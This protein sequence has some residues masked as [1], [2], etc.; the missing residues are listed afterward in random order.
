MVSSPCVDPRRSAVPPLT[1]RPA[2]LAAAGAANR[3]AAPMAGR[4]RRTPEPLPRQ[5]VA[6]GF[7]LSGYLGRTVSALAALAVVGSVST[8]GAPLP[9]PDSSGASAATTTATSV[10]EQLAAHRVR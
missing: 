2:E 6:A 1:R 10:A 9:R 5:L 3:P 8:L 7:V 4:H